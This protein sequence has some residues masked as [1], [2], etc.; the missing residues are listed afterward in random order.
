MIN[1][2]NSY[3]IN[4]ERNYHSDLGNHLDEE[5]EDDLIVFANA[6]SKAKELDKIVKKESKI[7]WVVALILISILGFTSFIS[8]LKRG[9]GKR[10]QV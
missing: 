8:I 1:N 3:S 7:P 9:S 5:E 6:R 2:N 4:E 10:D